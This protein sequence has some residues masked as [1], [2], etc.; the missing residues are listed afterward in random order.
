MSN[1]SSLYIVRQYDYFDNIWVDVSSPLSQED[2][3][4]LW[5]Q[6]TANG[7][8]NCKFEHRDYYAIFPSNTV[9]VFSS[10]A[11]VNEQGD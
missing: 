10:E 2:A 5:N 11:I 9:M 7:T 4:V 6:K 1:I 8:K 3:Q